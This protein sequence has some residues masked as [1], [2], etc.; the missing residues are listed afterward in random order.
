MTH[1]TQRSSNQINRTT[2]EAYKTWLDII[3]WFIDA[4]H[5]YTAIHMQPCREGSWIG[6]TRGFHR[7]SF[8]YFLLF[9]VIHYF[10]PMLIISHRHLF[11]TSRLWPT[12]L[13]W[14]SFSLS[15]SFIRFLSNAFF[16]KECPCNFG[17]DPLSVPTAFWRLCRCVIDS[18]I[19]WTRTISVVSSD[20]PRVVGI[21]L[22]RY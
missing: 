11:W 16:T 5:N 4:K 9:L 8:H 18:E 21:T 2:A 7:E 1:C 14:V 20:S 3:S 6:H 22:I 10:E 13:E 15:V 19:F 12:M 17:A